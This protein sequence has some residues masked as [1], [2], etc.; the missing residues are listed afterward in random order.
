MCVQ[1]GAGSL[2]KLTHTA[3]ATP[4]QFR[5]GLLFHIDTDLTPTKAGVGPSSSSWQQWLLL[6]LTLWGTPECNS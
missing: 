6:G 2:V 1:V 5:Y 4:T 3:P